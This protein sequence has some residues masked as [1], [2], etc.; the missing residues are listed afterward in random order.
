MPITER[1][2]PKFF[3]KSKNLN[4]LLWMVFSKHVLMQCEPSYEKE[5]GKLGKRDFSLGVLPR[6]KAAPKKG[7]YE[8]TALWLTR[9]DKGEVG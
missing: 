1:F 3:P 5:G 7:D 4:L 9:K 8:Q 6:S 2:L